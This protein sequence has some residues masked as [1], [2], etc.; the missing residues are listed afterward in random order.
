MSGL[1]MWFRQ[2]R[3]SWAERYPGQLRLSWLLL[4]CCLLVQFTPVLIEYQR[5]PGGTMAISMGMLQLIQRLLATLFSL[6]LMLQF[7]NLAGSCI[8]YCL[9]GSDMIGPQD[10]RSF[11]LQLR[12]N[13]LAISYRLAFRFVLPVLLVGLLADSLV[14][15]RVGVVEPLENLAAVLLWMLLSMQFALVA[16]QLGMRLPG[17]QFVLRS[18]LGILGMLL[19]L[20][21][22]IAPL[23]AIY[24]FSDNYFY[25]I[26]GGQLQLL[27]SGTPVLMQLLILYGLLRWTRVPPPD[28]ISELDRHSA[29][30][31]V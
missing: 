8:S 6:A 27:L 1:D 4:G 25:E 15:L 22:S 13:C 26:S 28:M 31:R 16:T 7:F 5:S 17:M 12:R 14:N 3:R 11:H 19:V 21:I 9:P 18:L 10:L 23:M 30:R 29:V 2:R 20:F 24:I